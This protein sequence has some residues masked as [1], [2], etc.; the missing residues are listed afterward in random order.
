[1]RRVAG[2]LAFTAIAAII[3]WLFPLFHVVTLK[4]ADAEKAAT[5]FNPTNFVDRFWNERLLKSLDR[6]VPAE[7]LVSEIKRDPTAARKKYGRNFGIGDSYLYFLSGTGRVLS[8]TDDEIALAISEGATQA[9]VSL[10][11]GLVFGNAVRDATGLLDVNN[12]PNS[13]D[14]NDISAELNRRVE[15][16]VLPK[17]R[18]QAKVGARI[19]FTGCAEVDDESSDL[20]PLKVI[21]VQAEIK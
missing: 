16:Q 4:Q 3:C 8:V 7:K 19:H 15:T 14:F 13:Q 10:Q 21:P 18:D 6:A 17:L 20:N 9:E 2:V 11:V 1:M 5:V 12:Y